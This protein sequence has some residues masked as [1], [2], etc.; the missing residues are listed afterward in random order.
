[1]CGRV[2]QKGGPREYGMML[3]V[4][5]TQQGGIPNAPPHYNG[6]PG[7]DYLVA[8]RH[9][10]TGERRLDL[11]RWG[12]IPSWAN[13]RKIAWKLINARGETVATTSAFKVAY[14]KR[15]CLIPVDLFYEWKK[16]GKEKHPYAIGMVSGEPFTLAGLWENWKNPETGTWERTFT[17]VTTAA[18][19]LVRKLHDRMPVVINADD[20]ERW[21]TDKDPSDLIHPYPAELMTMWPVSQRLNSPKNDTPDLLDEV[22]T[23]DGGG[24]DPMERADEGHAE[25]E[26][27]NS[28]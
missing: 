28:E 26:P 6:A 11:I 2:A 1:M 15:R 18:N 16:V 19:D 27:V 12:L 3:K 23:P 9:A 25:T 17:V 14:A 4:D 21:L 22:P 24:P 20:A 8:R 7:Q 5:W 13:D 10:E